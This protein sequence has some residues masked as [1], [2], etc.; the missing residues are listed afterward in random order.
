MRTIRVTWTGIFFLALLLYGAAATCLQAQDCSFASDCNGVINCASPCTVTIGQG[1]VTGV[2]P[3]PVCV[4]RKT[5]IKFVEGQGNYG[6]RLDLVNDPTNPA[7][8]LFADQR[9]SFSGFK[10]PAGTINITDSDTI[11][12][13]AGDCYKYSVKQCT[14]TDQCQT[15]D[16]KVIVNGGGGGGG[17]DASSRKGQDKPKK[18]Q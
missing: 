7:S 9:A 5:V 11:S 6:F 14:G 3:D 18:T 13:H 4:G 16:P 12:K 15:V 17:D 10:N 8:T 1:T 2:S